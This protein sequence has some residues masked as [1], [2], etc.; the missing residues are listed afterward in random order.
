MRAGLIG[1]N[2][3]PVLRV[4]RNMWDSLTPQQQTLFVTQQLMGFIA[5]PVYADMEGI[6]IVV[7][8]AALG[9]RHNKVVLEIGKKPAPAN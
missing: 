5:S 1:Q 8:D 9:P 2:T 3:V 6:Q 7:Y 4:D